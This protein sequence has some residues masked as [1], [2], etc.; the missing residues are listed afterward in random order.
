V[1]L[2]LEAVHFQIESIKRTPATRAPFPGRAA[3]P[4]RLLTLAEHC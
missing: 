3:P 1:V 2:N 4:G